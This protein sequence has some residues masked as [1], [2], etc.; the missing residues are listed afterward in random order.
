MQVPLPE[1]ADDKLHEPGPDPWWT[2]SLHYEF[3]SDD[4]SLG[5]YVTLTSL[6]N[7]RR[8]RYWACLVQPGRPLVTVIDNDIP[9]PAKAGST[10][11]RTTGL[12]AEHYFEDPLRHCS[13]ALEAFGVALDHPT[14]AYG[15]ARGDR[16]PLG[17]DLAWTTATSPFMWPSVANR[18]TDRIEVPC[19]VHGII[20][21]GDDE[22]E[23]TG[24]GHRRRVW[25]DAPWWQLHSA[26]G[27][28]A[29]GTSGERMSFVSIPGTNA[30]LACFTSPDSEP[31]IEAADVAFTQTENQLVAD[32][33]IELASGTCGIEQMAWA[34]VRAQG[35]GRTDVKLARAL[36][37]LRLGERVGAGW[38]EVGLA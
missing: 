17:F 20:Q 22:I 10:N 37:T 18:V 12:W 21:R 33:E 27:S 34:P 38:I 32:I 19:D 23:F 14:E 16:T 36:S 35:A 30:R 7:Q 13:L 2:E 29:L 15:A 26:C 24:L 6:P 9:L 28:A 1:P 4:A 31:T 5:G 11:L 25:G 3:A 8:V